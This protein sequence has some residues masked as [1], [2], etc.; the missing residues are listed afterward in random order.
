VQQLM[1]D[2]LGVDI[3]TGMIAKSRALTG[4][5]CEPLITE[6]HNYARTQPANVDETSL[7]QKDASETVEARTSRNIIARQG[8]RLRED[9]GLL[10]G[11]AQGP[12]GLVDVRRTRGDRTDE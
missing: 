4:S 10:S 12:V 8:V 1:H 7:R 3:S 5:I 9:I 6:L 11:I 2:I